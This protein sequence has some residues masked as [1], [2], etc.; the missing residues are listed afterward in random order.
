MQD[1]E[2][3]NYVPVID[4]NKLFYVK[5]QIKDASKIPQGYEKWLIRQINAMKCLTVE[6]CS[7]FE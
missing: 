5:L 4:L 2:D 1:H 7:S 6:E 3:E